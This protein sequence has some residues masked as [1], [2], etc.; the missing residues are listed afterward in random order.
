M[1][2]SFE[3]EAEYAIMVPIPNE[4][5]KNACPTAFKTVVSV[6]FDQSGTKRKLND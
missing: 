4:R 1:F 3:S 6:T 5:V 2:V